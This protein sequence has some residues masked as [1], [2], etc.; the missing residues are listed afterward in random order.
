MAVAIEFQ[1]LT[2]NWVR[3]Q[4]NVQNNPLVIKI[5]LQEV[6]RQRK[7]SKIRAV[8]EATGQLLDMLL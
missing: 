8:D 2:G 3:V 4:S 1:D 6:K 5:R 7:N